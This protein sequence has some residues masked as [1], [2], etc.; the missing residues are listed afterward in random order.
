VFGILSSSV[1]F[2]KRRA[3]NGMGK[4][5]IFA[6]SKQMCRLQNL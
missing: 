2:E 4:L 1:N 6:M 5:L 3:V